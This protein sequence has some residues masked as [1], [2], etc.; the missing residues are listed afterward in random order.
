MVRINSE[1]ELPERYREQLKKDDDI[2]GAAEGEV[3]KLTVPVKTPNLNEIINKSK[4][5]WSRYMRMK[6]E[7]QEQVEIA[8][9]MADVPKFESCKL[10]LIYVRQNRRE[11][12]DNI[13]AGKKFIIDGLV[14]Y[15]TLPD[16]GW[17]QIK[18]FQEEW[19]VGDKPEV[20]VYIIGG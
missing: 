14:S 2:V 3:F 19:K 15:G 4:T 11:D 16:D 5:H 6:E 13:V 7:I 8:C 12:P 18:G 17:G 1:G 20:I 10:K 9:A